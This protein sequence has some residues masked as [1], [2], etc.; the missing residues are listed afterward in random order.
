MSF[1]LYDNNFLLLESI[2]HEERA[3][4]DCVYEREKDI[5]ILSGAK[6]RPPLP[7]EYS[8]PHDDDRSFSVADPPS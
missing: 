3:I 4:I 2:H 1:K 5:L 7:L 6:G 8:M